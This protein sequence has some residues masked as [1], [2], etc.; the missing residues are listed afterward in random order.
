MGALTYWK[1]NRRSTQ[2]AYNATFG[3]L[4]AASA[5]FAPYMEANPASASGVA[6]SVEITATSA[7]LM[8]FC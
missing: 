7:P 8:A 4:A 5:A 6:T 3:A 1:P 2:I